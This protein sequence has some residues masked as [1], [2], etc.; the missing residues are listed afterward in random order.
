MTEDLEERREN[1]LNF[2]KG[3]KEYLVYILLTIIAW[4]GYYIRTLNLGLLRGK[5]LL[6]PDAHLVLRYVRYIFEHGKLFD[7]DPLR[8][9]PLGF[10]GLEEFSRSRAVR[11]SGGSRGYPTK[12][13]PR[14]SHAHPTRY[15]YRWRIC[16]GIG[17]L[18][19]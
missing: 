5:Y 3:K 2:L 15:S 6:D 12:A 14:F 9:Y 13:A 4:F 1:T 10:R 19:R 11:R 18:A 7:V 16:S 8:S 17:R